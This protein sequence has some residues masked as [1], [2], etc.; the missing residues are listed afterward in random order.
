MP[1][2]TRYLQKIFANNS[3]EVGVFGTGVD[4]ETSKNV[5]T[6]QSAEYE[7]GWSEAIITNKNYPIWQEMD[8]V[9]YG[10]SYQLKYLFQNGIPEWLS[11][12]TYYTNSYCR[13]GSDI[14]YSLQ[15]DNTNHN[16]ALHDGWWTLLNHANKDLT[17]LSSLG[18]ARLQY[19]PFSIN[20]GSVSAGNNNTLTYSGNTYT[21][22]PCTITSVD[23]RILVD[24]NT[25]SRT[26]SVS[27][28]GTYSIVKNVTNG[29]LSLVSPIVFSYQAP[30]NQTLYWLDR[31]TTP[32]SFKYYDTVLGQWR[33]AND[34]VYI[35][36]LTVSGGNIVS[37]TNRQFNNSGYYVTTYQEP[38]LLNSYKTGNTWYRK[39][40]QNWCEQGG[41]VTVGGVAGTYTVSFLN[42]FADTY[43][44]IQLTPV[45]SD[46]T[47]T[48]VLTP[49]EKNTGSMKIECNANIASF[50]W[51]VCG[52]IS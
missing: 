43:Y 48:P 11:T 5:E 16:P 51:T 50:Y 46:T 37:L 4:K 30:A 49:T 25:R 12:E 39:Y 42:A 34:L 44:S 19:A 6:L 47:V 9:Q 24:S 52:Y 1:K 14:Y 31:A 28:D 22:A 15:D 2:L 8:G 38:Y 23:G 33:P 36:T 3:N 40:F 10:L 32:A 27:S 20:A 35:G 26:L 29:D 18:N 41:L 13:Y 7:G 21:C 17:N 45:R